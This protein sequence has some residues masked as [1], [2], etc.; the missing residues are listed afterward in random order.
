MECKQFFWAILLI[1]SSALTKVYGIFQLGLL[2]CYPQF[3]RNLGYAVLSGLL[4]LLLPLLKLST[5]AFI[6]YHQEW[7]Y[8][9]SSHHSGKIF[10]SIYYAEPW[11][12]ATRPYYRYVQMGSLAVLNSILLLNRKKYSN[13]AFRA[14]ALAI[15]MGW[16]ILF[17]DAAEKHT[18]VIALAGYM[19]WYWSFAERQQIDKILFWA[20]FILFCIVPIDIFVPKALMNIICYTL[21]LNVWVF[22]FLWLRMVWI[23]FLKP[24]PLNLSTTS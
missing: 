2:L 4:L 15:L 22:L 8:S 6:P 9:L 7:L 20:T 14:Q 11:L 21:W 10:D 19:L 3:W 1:M 12:S 24:Q 13:W 17:S 16:T 23:T 5:E 18:Y